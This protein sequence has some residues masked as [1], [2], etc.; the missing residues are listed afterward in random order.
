MTKSMRMLF[1]TTRLFTNDLRIFNCAYVA[2][3]CVME[4]VSSKAR[5]TVPTS[6]CGWS[7]T[8]NGVTVLPLGLGNCQF[9]F[10]GKIDV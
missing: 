1:I 3:L 9:Y 10:S 6:G 8:E 2:I 5:L 4:Y 7:N